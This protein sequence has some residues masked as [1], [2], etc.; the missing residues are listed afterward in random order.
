M[1]KNIFLIV[2]LLFAICVSAQ[3]SVKVEVVKTIKVTTAQ[4]DSYAVPVG[5]I[6]KIYNTTTDRW[7]ENDG[8]VGW[9]AS[10]T[11]GGGGGADGDSAYQVAVNNGFNGTEAQW[12]ASL[13]GAQGPAG[14]DGQDGA[15]GIQGIQGVAGNDGTNGSDGADGIGVPT[16]GTTGQLLAKKTNADNDTEWVDAPTG[17]ETDPTVPA[18]VKAITSQNITDWSNSNGDLWSDPV[19]SNIIP[20]GDNTRDFGTGAL[21]FRHGRFAGNLYSQTINADLAYLGNVILTP[22]LFGGQAQENSLGVKTA[23]GKRL[24]LHVGAPDNWKDIAFLDEVE[25]S[26]GNPTSNGQILASQTDGTR[27]WINPTGGSSSNFGIVASG[28][29]SG[30]GTGV[31]TIIHGLGYVPDASRITVQSQDAI[32]TIAFGIE[33]V[34]TTSFDVRSNGSADF[35]HWKIFGTNST[36]PLVGSEVVSLIDTELG[37]TTWKTGGS[38][39]D[40]QTLAEVLAQGADANNVAITNLGGIDSNGNI[41]INGNNAFMILDRN[42]NTNFGAFQFKTNNTLNATV[43]YRNDATGKFEFF[44]DDATANRG[45]ALVFDTDNETIFN[46]DG[47]DLDFRVEGSN[48]QNLIFVDASTDR[49]GIGKNNPTTALD[50]NG[51]VTATAF[52]GDGSGLTGISGGGSADGLGTD[53]DKGDITVGGTGTTLT[54]DNLAVTS[55]KIADNAV[56]TAKINNGAVTDPKI[57]TGI[58]ANK[59]GGGNVSTTE[60]DRL[61]GVTSNIQNQIDALEEITPATITTSRNVVASDADGVNFVTGTTTLSVATNAVESIPINTGIVFINDGTDVVTIDFLSGVA[62]TDVVLSKNGHSVTIL[63]TGTD[64][65]KVINAPRTILEPFTSTGTAISLN[66]QGYYNTVNSATTYTTTDSVTGGFARVL[67]NT[68]SEPAVTGATKITGA[69]WVTG[70]DMFMVVSYNGTSTEY[71]FLE[72]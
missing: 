5:Q 44:L 11:G 4:R 17:T 62:G 1:K 50:V 40:D 55:T 29:D 2:G 54:I 52:I 57:G 13:I 19:N 23:G 63:K 7:E 14:N 67:I 51:T 61:N 15:Q 69:D 41:T 18:H 47:G 37:Q 42:A 12:L 26:L 45:S 53:G 25:G 30:T 28:T 46:E 16:G 60:Y 21:R 39:T 32:S 24:T 71:Y 56:V 6:W 27:S 31:Q 9:V 43:G 49:V 48:N 20:D 33:N 8:G 22:A 70:T 59:I 64:T 10:D 34:T 72:K 58:N 66:G 3:R 38:S 68:T 36:T 35:F 65:W